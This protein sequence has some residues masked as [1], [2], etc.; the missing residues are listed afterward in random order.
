M[1]RPPDRAVGSSGLF[2]RS[3]CTGWSGFWASPFCLV[4]SGRKGLTGSIARGRVAVPANCDEGQVE[5][6][7]D[8]LLLLRSLLLPGRPKWIVIPASGSAALRHLR[9]RA[10]LKP[11]RLR[12]TKPADIRMG[13]TRSHPSGESG[14]HAWQPACRSVSCRQR[15]LLPPPHEE[16]RSAARRARTT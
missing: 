13:G 3:W 16:R 12:L 11:V 8:D 4:R 6:G 7:A 5:V 1:M 15:L 10:R 14:R 2:E 9:E